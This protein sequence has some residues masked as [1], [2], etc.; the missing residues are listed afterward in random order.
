MVVQALVFSKKFQ[1]WLWIFDRVE[2]ETTMIMYVLYNYIKR[3]YVKWTLSS[4]THKSREV[5]YS[6]ILKYNH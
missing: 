4:I 5:F 2:G 1:F 3:E 6:L